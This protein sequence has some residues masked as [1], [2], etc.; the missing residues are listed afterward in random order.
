MNTGNT[1]IVHNFLETEEAVLVSLPKVLSMHTQY[2]HANVFF[3][4]L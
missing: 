3:R 1:I 4:A 2:L